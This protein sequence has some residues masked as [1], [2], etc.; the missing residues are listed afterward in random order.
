MRV[1]VIVL[2]SCVFVTLTSSLGLYLDDVDHLDAFVKGTKQH[3]N[4]VMGRHFAQGKLESFAM[5]KPSAQGE[6]S[7]VVSGGNRISTLGLLFFLF[8]C[9]LFSFLFVCCLFSF[10][11]T[12]TTRID[13][14]GSLLE[15]QFF[16]EVFMYTEGGGGSNCF[17][18]N[19]DGVCDAFVASRR[20]IDVEFVI[21][22]GVEGRQLFIKKMM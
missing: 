15:E 17:D 8:V 4:V 11:L 7:R 18:W 21:W 12:V 20:G 10:L 5:V 3:R 22:S 1:A 16:D 14:G 13:Q 2:L 6:Y 19:S 9:C